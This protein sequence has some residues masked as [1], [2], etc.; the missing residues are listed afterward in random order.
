MAALAVGAL[1]EDDIIAQTPNTTARI[2][3][4]PMPDA[5]A[6]AWQHYQ[7]LY[8]ALKQ[9]RQGARS[10]NGNNGNG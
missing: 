4:D 1:N 8:P 9:A 10:R 7:H 5:L 2:T 6:Y 3:P